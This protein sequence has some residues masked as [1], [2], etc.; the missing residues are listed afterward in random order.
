MVEPSDEFPRLV[1]K[2]LIR[3]ILAIGCSFPFAFVL[4]FLFEIINKRLVDLFCGH[5]AVILIPLM[6]IFNYFLLGYLPLFNK[7]KKKSL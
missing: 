2:E 5:N 4:C 1:R 6:G 3:Y 7:K